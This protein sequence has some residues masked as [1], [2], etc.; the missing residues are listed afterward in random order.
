[1][2]SDQVTIEEA[3]RMILRACIRQGLADQGQLDFVYDVDCIS[4][5]DLAEPANVLSNL[6]RS[7][8]LDGKSHPSILRE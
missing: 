6:L 2:D 5:G 4:A 3:V 7:G 8:R 1:M